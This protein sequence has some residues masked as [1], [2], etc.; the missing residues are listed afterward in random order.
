M[1]HRAL[2]VS[3]SCTAI[4]I[5][6]APILLF[7]DNA[8][9]H[10]MVEDRY[11]GF[12][13]PADYLDFDVPP[14]RFEVEVLSDGEM[15]ADED[16]R[17]WKERD[18][19]CVRRGDFHAEVNLLSG[20]GHIRQELNPFAL[21][22]I[23]RIVHTLH[24]APRHGFLLHAASAIRNGMAFVLSGVSGAGKT[25]MS[26]CAPNDAVL[27]TD[28]ISYIRRDGDGY[29]ACGTP[30]AG[31]LGTPGENV[32]APISKLFFLDKGPHNRTQQLDKPQA[33]RMLLRN[34]LFFCQEDELTRQVFDSACEFIE[35]VP[36][37]RL[38]FV[39]DASAWDLVR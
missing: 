7:S 22:S 5:G 17:V 3:T 12:K 2:A 15:C 28:E 13:R 29:C 10:A 27:L 6:G 19:W 25:T 23:L 18:F 26:R 39:P 30:F 38:T 31:D 1:S 24:L 32:S 4:E 16:V 11:P 36:V 35:R 21:N 14:L 20:T 37:H 33:L 8:A 9:F 34:V